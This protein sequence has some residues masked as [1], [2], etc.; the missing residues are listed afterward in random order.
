MWLQLLRPLLFQV[1][2]FGV[3]HCL[4]AHTCIQAQFQSGGVTVYN[5]TQYA[6]YVGILTGFKR[7]AFSIT[8][9][10]RIDSELDLP[11]IEWF[12]GKYQGNFVGFLNRQVLQNNNSYAAAFTELTTVNTIAPVYLIL[13]GSNAGDGVVITRE[14]DVVI[15]IWSAFLTLKRSKHG[16]IFVLAALQSQLA[17]GSWFLLETS[18]V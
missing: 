10:T 4:Y 16:L 13:G 2:Y 7:G 9:D 12:E 3:S 15:N 5:A 6:G 17:N 1:G 8:V 11:L 18:M 14:A